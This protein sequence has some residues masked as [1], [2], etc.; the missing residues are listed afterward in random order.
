VTAKECF[1]NLVNLGKS[2]LCLFPTCKACQMFN[3]EMIEGLNTEV[4]KFLC[5]DEVDET[6]G[7]HKWTKAA[8]EQ[9]KKIE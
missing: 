1:T 6:M 3:I 9:F 7:K 4:T 5:I 2:P 8:E